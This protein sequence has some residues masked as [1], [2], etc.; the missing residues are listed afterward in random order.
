MNGLTGVMVK[1]IENLVINPV[2]RVATEA[3]NILVHTKA[4][5][6]MPKNDGV[7]IVLTASDIEMSDFNLNPFIAFAGGFPKV[8]VQKKLY[9]DLPFNLDSTAKYAPYGL[10]KVE[11]LLIEEFGEENVVTVHPSN[12]HRFIGPK[13]KIVAISTMDPLGTGFVSRTYTS[14]LGLNGKP[15]TL[16]EFED[17][18]LIGQAE[19]SIIQIFRRMLDGEK[20]EKVITMQIPKDTEISVIKKPS[21]YGTVEVMRGCGRGCAF[22]SPTL[23]QRY[24]FHV[25]HILKE[26]ELNAKNGTKMIILQTDDI[27]LYNSKPKFILKTKVH[28]K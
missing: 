4:D 26:V 27:F 1:T 3:S 18:V 9:P 12:L 10:R 11:S 17:S 13:T 8:L 19:H 15:A 2:S 7:M 16:A 14:I 25:E 5:D 21:I 20:L 6:V 24:S 22:C 28:P 23:R